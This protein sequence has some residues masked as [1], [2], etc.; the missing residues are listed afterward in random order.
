[1]NNQSTNST[2]A[3]KPR[4]LVVKLLK[5]MLILGGLI[6][7]L[8]TAAVVWLRTDSA[9]NFLARKTEDLLAAQGLY[10]KIDAISG[11]LPSRLQLRGVE[12]SDAGGVWLRTKGLALELSLSGLLSK[13][14]VI[15]TIS[16]DAPEL[17]RLPE[18]AAA[19][20]SPMQDQNNAGFSLNLPLNINLKQLSVKQAVIPWEILGL[21]PEPTLLPPITS[22]AEPASPL[23]TVSLFEQAMHHPLQ[24]NLNATGQLVQGTIQ[25]ELEAELRSGDTLGL[26]LTLAPARFSKPDE[27][28]MEFSAVAQMNVHW[29]NRTD[30]LKLAAEATQTG[31][32]W[33]VK[34]F[35]LNGL[36]LD[37]NAN[38]EIDPDQKLL[39]ALLELNAADN[40]EW[41]TVCEQIFGMKKDLPAALGN[42]LQVEITAQ[43]AQPGN[44]SI[45]ISRLIA[46]LISGEGHALLHLPDE[47][48]PGAGFAG[49]IDADMNFSVKDLAPF[50]NSLSGP[51]NAA[52]NA[53]GDFNQANLRLMLNSPNLSVAEDEVHGLEF[54][55]NAALQNT[56]TDKPAG[57]GSISISSTSIPSR[58]SELVSLNSNWQ[59]S[60]D[61]IRGAESGFISLKD[62]SL[63]GFGVKANGQTNIELTS[64]FFNNN[65]KKPALWPQGLAINGGLH[66]AVDDW[67][68]LSRLAGI[69][70]L[71]EA[72][73]ATI[74]L[75]NVHNV[76]SGQLNLKVKSLDLPLQ[77]VQ[78]DRL[79]MR[80]QAAF[81]AQEP[82]LELA[83]AGMTGKAGKFQWSGFNLN[84]SG[85]A[86]K[87]D[88]NLSIQES[89][90]EDAVSA[91]SKRNATK[92]AAS[93]ENMLALAG[94]YD[95]AGQTVKLDSLDAKYPSSRLKFH[96]LSPARF[97][98]DKGIRVNGLD[99]GLEPKGNL[100]ADAEISP[101]SFKAKL[102]LSELPLS[103]INTLAGSS[104]PP[105]NLDISADFQNVNRGRLNAA[106][107]LDKY[108]AGLSNPL[109]AGAETG[110]QTSPFSSKAENLPPTEVPVSDSCDAG[111][112][113]HSPA[114]ILLQA[115][116]SGKS[117]RP[118]LNGEVN[119]NFQNSAV[120][121]N[122]VASTTKAPL[123]FSLPLS[124]SSSGLPLPDMHA[125]FQANLTWLG[126]IAPLWELAPMPNMECSGLAQ[127][128]FQL[129]GSLNSPQF[130][131]K[132]YVAAGE[133]EDKE[134]G[135]L[136]SNIMLQ[137]AANS[138][139]ELS[140]I[141]SATDGGKGKLAFEG[142]YNPNIESALNLRG[143]IEHLT[144]LQRDDLSLTITGL[145]NVYGP[146]SQLNVKINTIIE[147]GEIILLDSLMTGKVATLEI[148]DPN[149]ALL[150]K[151]SGAN[152]DIHVNVPRQFYI[153][154]R[155]LDSEWKGNLAI[156]GTS[157]SP[158]LLGS[159]NPVRGQFNLL[160][161]NFNLEQG[162][163][164][165]AGGSKINPALN[166]TLTYTATNLEAKILV[167]GTLDAPALSLE[168]TP[169]LPQDEV[170]AQVLFGKDISELSRFEALQLASGLHT[171]TTGDSSFNILADMRETT[172]LD[173]LRLGSSAD[174]QQQGPQASSQSGVSN[175]TSPGA[176]GR[177]GDQG[178]T[179]LEAGK[180]ISDSIYVGVEK[181]IAQESTAV[182]VDIEL[183]P[184][185]TLQGSTSTESSQVGLGWKKDY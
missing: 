142:S 126:E 90:N 57:T 36:G 55:L 176:A 107:R 106:L 51:L 169:S 174:S 111:T 7:L 52:F 68:P 179:T 54:A 41:Q 123:T 75:A 10:L 91:K 139:K 21:T 8:I 29:L 167:R 46:G 9:A 94:Q 5:A 173:V 50:H 118:V 178:E 183:Y 101:H 73:E 93:A 42:P 4:K 34:Q 65:D 115:D 48:K 14:L 102:E 70:V 185:V 45:E 69:P 149:A 156:T 182:R 163:I 95:L 58:E 92:P 137:A 66:L 67:N 155:G 162:S 89:S 131:G 117:G 109:S 27:Q 16:I 135:L 38:G 184:N 82:D 22:E 64:P 161:R 47:T 15:D 32:A 59:F 132:A 121:Q 153:R 110:A 172:G 2:P 12:L 108:A 119:F 100:K 23:P 74:D 35:R 128:N 140:I 104:L 168:S 53:T 136:L 80:A 39:N 127:V 170:L 143:R 96:L 77:E 19:E 84:V 62:F 60:L 44:Y 147:Q 165:F 152:L 130:N 164:E 151:N 18:L 105:G 113:A 87:G 56:L 154:G 28:N 26:D 61:R 134:L 98:F 3:S 145:A 166:L 24:I 146:L 20:S 76:Q 31:S 37:V 97:A 6:A 120:P 72:A 17:I 71:G 129:R 133:F 116:L 63:L 86:G 88:F 138:Q 25:A 40:A 78:A 33:Q 124:V 114:N 103:T 13:T 1:M 11:P 148:S 99:L 81:K 180:Y 125:P 150:E 171:L 157:A 177:P 122:S 85:T 160:S 83:M 141:L 49:N 43:T 112:T 79:V 181:G 175:L 30:H 159:L 158:V 144:P